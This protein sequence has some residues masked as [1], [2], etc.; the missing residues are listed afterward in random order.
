MTKLLLI[1]TTLHIGS[2]GR[3]VEQIASTA[4]MKGVECFIA[5]G[6]RYVGKSNSNAIKIS[7]KLDN[8]IHAIEGEYL[9][10]H[11][12]GS[13]LFTTKFVELIREL[14][15]DI[16]HLHNIHGYYLNHKVLLEYLSKS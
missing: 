6:G 7:S 4:S 16:I 12:L 14:N 5:H 2:T 15:P 10:R 13:Y 1:N 9:G 11:G 8:Y 3:I